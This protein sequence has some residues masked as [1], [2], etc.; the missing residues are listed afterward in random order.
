MLS[1]SHP[2]T[3]GLAS[4][5]I[6]PPCERGMCLCVCVLCVSRVCGGKGGEGWVWVGG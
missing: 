5:T 6:I 3:L 2:S 4:E 1:P